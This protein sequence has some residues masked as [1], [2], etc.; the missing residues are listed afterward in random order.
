MNEDKKMFNTMLFVYI[1][2]LLIYLLG[3]IAIMYF[4]VRPLAMWIISK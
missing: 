3:F 1:S 2:T 4:V